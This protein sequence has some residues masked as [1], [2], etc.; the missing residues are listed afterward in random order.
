MEFNEKYCLSWNQNSFSN[1]TYLFNLF[2]FV[3]LQIPG[4]KNYMRNYTKMLFWTNPGSSTQQNSSCTATYLPSHEPSK[5]DIL[6]ITGE[7]RINS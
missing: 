6:D 7:I 3:V 4:E 1:L 2:N 5:K